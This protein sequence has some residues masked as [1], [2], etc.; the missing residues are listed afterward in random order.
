M[1]AVSYRVGDEVFRAILQPGRVFHLV[2]GVAFFVAPY[3]ARSAA[4]CACH[5]NVPFPS[6]AYRVY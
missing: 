5:D 4:A 1:R 3:G 6:Q 2:G